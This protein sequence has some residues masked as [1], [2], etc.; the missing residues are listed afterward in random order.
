MVPA[1]RVRLNAIAAKAGQALF[2]AKDPEGMCASAP[3]FKSAMT[4]STLCKG[5]H[6]VD[7][8]D[9]WVMSMFR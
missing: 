5:L 9:V 7:Y 1:A 4:C 6:N 8:L 2:A 3:P